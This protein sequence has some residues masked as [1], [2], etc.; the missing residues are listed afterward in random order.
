MFKL[1]VFI[2]ESCSLSNRQACCISLHQNP[3]VNNFSLTLK[4]TAK[5]KKRTSALRS[6]T[7]KQFNYTDQAVLLEVV[8]L[9]LWICI[10]GLYPAKWTIWIFPPLPALLLTMSRM[11]S[12]SPEGG[13]AGVTSSKWHKHLLVVCSSSWLIY[14]PKKSSF[15]RIM[16][17]LH[18]FFPGR[19]CHWAKFSQNKLGNT[20]HVLFSV[21][22]LSYKTVSKI[23]T[24]WY[25][26]PQPN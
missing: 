3:T 7:P 10:L 19:M 6:Q 11:G 20:K 18:L 4:V 26:D 9:R 12:V 8:V 13:T 25:A 21:I 23:F 5:R 22:F 1:T 24:V 2:T 15:S 16:F 17:S 14:A